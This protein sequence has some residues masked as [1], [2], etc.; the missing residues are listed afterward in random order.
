MSD[1][2]FLNFWP[3]EKQVPSGSARHG[4]VELQICKRC[5]GGFGE[6]MA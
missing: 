4:V 3:D 6:R 1:T 5:R 2:K